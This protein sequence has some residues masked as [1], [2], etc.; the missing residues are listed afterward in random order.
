MN[1]V[2]KKNITGGV[3]IKLQCA[4]GPECKITESA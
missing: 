4:M 2:M 1:R 3:D